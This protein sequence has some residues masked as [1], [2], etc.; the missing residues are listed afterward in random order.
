VKASEF[1]LAGGEGLSFWG[2]VSP[3][4]PKRDLAYPS[5]HLAVW[6]QGVAVG[7]CALE[8]THKQLGSR[9]INPPPPWS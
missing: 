6:S 4:P 9:T 8:W 2:K 3:N 7:G 1:L 5:K